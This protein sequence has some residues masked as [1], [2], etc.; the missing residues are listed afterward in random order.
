MSWVINK[1]IF[2]NFKVF[3]EEFTF[4]L[5]GKNFLLFGENGSGKSSLNWGLYTFLQSVLKLPNLTEAQKYF[6]ATHEQNLRNRFSNDADYS[7]IKVEFKNETTGAPLMLE[8]SAT[9]VNTNAAHGLNIRFSL[10][11]SDFLNYKYLHSVFDFSNSAKNDLFPLFYQDIF[12]I[13]DFRIEVRDINGISLGKNMKLWWK[14]LQTILASLPRGSGKNRNHILRR[15]TAWEAFKVQLKDFNTQLKLFLESIEITANRTLTARFDAPVNI[16]FNY[17][18]ATWVKAAADPAKGNLRLSSPKIIT[19]AKY[20]HPN[21]V[22][23]NVNHPRSFFNEAMLSKIALALRLAVTDKRIGTGADVCKILVIDDLL[24]SLDMANRCKVID[25]LLEYTSQFQMMILTH[26]RSFYQVV[27]NKIVERKELSKW[28]CSQIYIKPTLNQNDV[29]VPVLVMNKPGLDQAKDFYL[30]GE[31]EATIVTLRKECEASIKR[32][33][34]F[35]DIINAEKA[36]IKG[37]IKFVDLSKM[38]DR[39]P[40]FYSKHYSTDISMQMPN[41]TPNLHTFRELLLNKAAHNDYDTPR[42]KHEIEDAF[43]EI[44]I[45][46]T[47]QK[48]I[49]VKSNQV[50]IDEYEFKVYDTNGTNHCLGFRFEEVFSVLSVN[51]RDY[52]M[53]SAIVLTASGKRSSI[54]CEITQFCASCRAQVPSDILDNITHI[55]NGMKMKDE[56]IA[57]Q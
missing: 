41:V 51:G 16:E 39:I 21:A 27:Y 30:R 10:G 43:N 5:D 11:A 29:P 40:S 48:H 44:E 52:Y 17:Q 38:I 45:L 37:E 50:N 25:I 28:K 35:I 3:K 4:S 36:Y 12:P 22:N 46:S 19:T 7:G 6:Q 20:L 15:G 33:I 53:D 49:L 2:E 47:I 42:F 34:P 24:I 1:I 23:G 9:I 14:T 31:F 57:I 55:M 32:I 56:L 54:K 8:D 18:E 26:D 13:D